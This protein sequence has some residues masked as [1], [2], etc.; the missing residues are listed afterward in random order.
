ML[1]IRARQRSPALCR[2]RGACAATFRPTASVSARVRSVLMCGGVVSRA[3]AFIRLLVASNLRHALLTV[4]LALAALLVPSPAVASTQP[5]AT[6]VTSTPEAS[7]VECRIYVI[8]LRVP[9]DRANARRLGAPDARSVA[10]T[11]GR[12]APP[13]ARGRHIN[14]GAG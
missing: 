8:A 3:V 14:S 12:A 6:P 13:N 2:S 11:T 1:R 5:E 7:P 4:L 10:S 9:H